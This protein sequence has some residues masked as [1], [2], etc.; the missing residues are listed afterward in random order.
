[1]LKYYEINKI[2]IF[3]HCLLKTIANSLDLGD[4]KA[5]HYVFR[6]FYMN[7]Y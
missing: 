3:D 4:F 1:L 6:A 5:N 7:S 2:M